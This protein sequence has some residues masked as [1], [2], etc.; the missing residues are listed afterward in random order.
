MTTTFTPLK[1][2]DLALAMATFFADWGDISP[3][4]FEIVALGMAGDELIKD[5]Q[6]RLDSIEAAKRLDDAARWINAIVT[7]KP[8]FK[9]A[10]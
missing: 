7:A 8:Y 5:E 9:P 4:V 2:T 10:P 6:M 1:P 3:K